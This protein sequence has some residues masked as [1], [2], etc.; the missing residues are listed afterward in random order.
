MCSIKQT[1][2]QESRMVLAFIF[3]HFRRCSAG[4]G[5]GRFNLSTSKAT[6]MLIP[7]TFGGS[8]VCLRQTIPISNFRHHSNSCA[9]IGVWTALL[10]LGSQ[11]GLPKASFALQ[12]CS[13]HGRF[14]YL[15]TLSAR[16]TS[17]RRKLGCTSTNSG[18]SFPV[19]HK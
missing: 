9:V 12:L 6:K 2:E 16:V 1:R 7:S 10:T 3:A 18:S 15:S 11:E 19:W 4:P 13:V 5:S 8:N 17:A 14:C